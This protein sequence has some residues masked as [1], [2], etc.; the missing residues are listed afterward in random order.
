MDPNTQAHVFL[1]GFH[2]ACAALT[3][4]AA[5]FSRG[6][7]FQGHVLIQGTGGVAVFAIQFAKAMGARVTVISS[8]D[9]KLARAAELGSGY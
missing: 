9:E 4:W 6:V 7:C 5:L 8:S 3:A 2:P 1:G